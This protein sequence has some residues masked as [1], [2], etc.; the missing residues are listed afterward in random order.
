MALVGLAVGLSSCQNSCQQICG[1]MASYARD[2]GYT[3]TANQVQECVSEQA[4]DASKEDRAV[5]RDLGSRSA[6]RSQWT[7]DDLGVYFRSQS[8]DEFAPDCVD[9][10]W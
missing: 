5:C 4:G 9:T 8:S 10:A 2:C 1:R 7:C 6:I 3:V